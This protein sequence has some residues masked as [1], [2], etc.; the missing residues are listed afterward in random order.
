[1]TERTIFKDLKKAFSPAIN[2]I[3]IETG[4]TASGIPDVYYSSMVNDEVGW[5]ELKVAKVK[6]DGLIEIPYRPGQ[7]NWL[8]DYVGRNKKGY[9][10]IYFEG[11]YYLTQVFE[12]FFLDKKHLLESSLLVRNSLYSQKLFEELTR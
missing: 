8:K 12:R 5:I 6:K 1:M 9:T 11:I 4:S 10:L 2:F 7:I 3:S